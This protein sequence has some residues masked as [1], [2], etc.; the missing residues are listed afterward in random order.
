[1]LC[2]YKANLP[3]MNNILHE[4]S[5]SAIDSPSGDVCIVEHGC[6]FINSKF[7]E[8]KVMYND[9]YLVGQNISPSF[10]KHL[11]D[12]KRI[13]K[14]INP[15]S[16]FEIGCSDGYFVEIL[17][18]DGFDSYGV[19]PSYVGSNRKIKQ[20]NF[21]KEKNIKHDLIILRH[22]LEHIKNP[23]SFLND[24]KHATNEDTLIYI[25]V[26]SLNWIIDNGAF[27]DFT[28]EHV[29]YFNLAS[30]NHF[31]SS[32][33]ESG[34]LF[35]KQYI[36]IVAKISSLTDRFN[37]L[38][39]VDTGGDQYIAERIKHMKN[40]ENTVA[41]NISKL[42]GP[43]YICSAA[44]KGVIFSSLLA[45]NKNLRNFSFD[46]VEINPVKVGKYIPVIGKKILNQADV[47]NGNMI[48]M[49]SNY[50]Q[51]VKN[52]VSSNVRVF[53]LIDFM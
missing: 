11:A 18:N 47:D 52:A 35:S 49:N 46:V 14:R 15:S 50:L 24:I 10:M 45:A 31:F 28:Y 40:I 6:Y 33:V 8:K 53:E 38:V 21:N 37:E 19:D 29:N 5:N 3:I 16:T 44:G 1:M 25:E 12:V 13:I 30:F 41:H 43:V 2:L 36:Y 4:S 22:V 48:V 9:Q 39:N 32:I 26:P 34:E 17:N 23:V 20:N 27:Y 42:D 7:D 51:D